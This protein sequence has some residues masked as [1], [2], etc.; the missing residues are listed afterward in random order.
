MS[1][2][3]NKRMMV[4]DARGKFRKANGEDI[5]IMG[6][7]P[8]CRHFLIRVYDGDPKDS[9]IDPRLFR[10]RCF[11]C[12]PRTEEEIREEKRKREKSLFKIEDLFKPQEPK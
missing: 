2:Y 9:M 6:V 4:R 1:K 3:K 12:E 7:C 11:T 5:G 10:N 8:T